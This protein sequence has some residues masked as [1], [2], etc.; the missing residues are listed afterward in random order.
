[1][2]DT[3]PR[4]DPLK[5]QRDLTG[6]AEPRP[7]ELEERLDEVESQNLGEVGAGPD[8]RVPRPPDEDVTSNPEPPGPALQGEDEGP[9]GEGGQDLGGAGGGGR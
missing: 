4:G 6:E 1:M 5:P 8:G 9:Q 2:S 3:V 7:T